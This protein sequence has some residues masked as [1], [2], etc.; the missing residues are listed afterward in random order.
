MATTAE[1]VR[2]SLWENLQGVLNEN[3]LPAGQGDSRRGNLLPLICIG[4]LE[5]INA[6]LLYWEY[7]SRH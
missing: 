4:K 5:R 1:R 6:T 3:K 2:A 7:I